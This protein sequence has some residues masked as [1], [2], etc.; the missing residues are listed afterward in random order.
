MTETATPELRRVL[1]KQINAAI[2]LH[3]QVFIYVPKRLISRL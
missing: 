3:E 2:K 1:V